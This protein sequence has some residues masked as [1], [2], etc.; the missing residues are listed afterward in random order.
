MVEVFLS[1]EVFLCVNLS[2]EGVRVNV[3]EAFVCC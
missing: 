3:V 1:V 2:L